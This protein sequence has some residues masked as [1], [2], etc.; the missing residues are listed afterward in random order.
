MSIR[1]KIIGVC[2]VVGLLLGGQ[3]TFAAENALQA[4]KNEKKVASHLQEQIVNI[5]SSVVK[6]EKILT[7]FNS[8]APKKYKENEIIV[9]FKNNYSV[10]NLGTMGAFLGLTSAKVLNKEGTHLLKFSKTKKMEEVLQKLNASPNVEYAEPNYLFK[11]TA[12]TDPLYS[13][14]W[15]LKNTGQDILG[16]IGK[17][18]IDINVESAW[19]KTKGS[20]ALV[21]GVIDTG[22]D[23]NHPDLKDKIWVNTGEIPNDGIDN[24]KNG[25]IDDVNG[26][27]FYDKNNRLFIR[28]EEDFHGTHVA[29]TI[30]AKADNIG[31]VGVA[32]N[33]KIMPLKFIGPWGGY[34]ADAILAIE[35]AK[36]KG[37]KILNNSWGGPENSQALYDAIKNSGT[38]FIA[39]A[40]NDGMNADSSPMY[41]A[42]YNLPNILSV[43][44]INNTGNL[45]IFSNYGVKS[46][47]VAAP[48]EGILSTFPMLEG[49]YST[50]YEYLDGTSMATPH[51][52]GVAALVQSAHP[53]YTPAQ[54]KDA[55][56]RTITKLSSLSGKVATGGL[57]NAGNA[58]HFE[59]DSEIPGIPW[60]GTTISSTLDA[61]KDK[62]D[63]YSIK[64]L[65][66]E[67]LKVTLTGDAGTDFDLYLYNDTATTVNSST[68]IAAHSETA[69]TSN[70]SF[71]F[72]APKTG[73]YYLN[74]YAYSGAGK[75]T[76]SVTEGIGAGIYENTSQYLGYEGTWNK[77][78]DGSASE[79]SYTSTNQTGSTVKIVF[80]GTGISYKAVKNNKQ[81]IVKVTLDGKSA[82]YSLYSASVQYG[83]EIFKKTGLPA[84]KHVLT[85][86][87]TGQSDPS[88]RKTSTE[89]NVDSIT[90]LK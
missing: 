33:V 86:E 41:P 84:G 63:V 13:E 6:K 74:A 42:A 55:I 23:I 25:Y 10:K 45:S 72:T 15:G 83:T 50:A 22:M 7:Y 80:N 24:D 53:S 19:T 81:G 77:V 43:A 32:P 56:M 52:T 68:G 78:S 37:V 70:E 38:L 54:I 75:Y 62:N 9:K 79:S 8:N 14:L 61:V 89:V 16:Q 76:L 27:N 17:K 67:K 82:N 26:W 11:P 21:I 1:T 71:T 36:S 40:G 88:S 20:S 73:T 31:V 34:E 39:A 30:A 47:D 87:W 35:Y 69:K 29:G 85:I 18:G 51:V 64:L 59:A 49:D 46:V 12:V 90:V 3:T 5:D 60:K 66:G 48:G 58:I 57:V 65:K 2:G 28:A 44:A 4:V